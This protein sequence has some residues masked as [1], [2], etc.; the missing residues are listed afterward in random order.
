MLKIFINGLFRHIKSDVS[1]V[2]CVYFL[3]P[4]QLSFV[5]KSLQQLLCNSQCSERSLSNLPSDLR[6]H[7]DTISL[8]DY[9]VP[10]HSIATIP[11]GIP[12]RGRMRLSLVRD[13]IVLAGK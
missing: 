1:L 8:S 11:I 6:S 10:L 4:A 3:C 7:F 5:G 2:L 9:S 12:E 13:H